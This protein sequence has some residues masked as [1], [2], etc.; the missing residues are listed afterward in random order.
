MFSRHV[1]GV[2][3]ASNE[4]LR[5]GEYI[6]LPS[7]SLFTEDHYFLEI[8]LI[9]W[10][11]LQTKGDRVILN[12]R[13]YTGCSLNDLLVSSGALYPTISGMLLYANDEKIGSLMTYRD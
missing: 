4:T 12:S 9:S 2:I 3:F 11:N 6:F 7:L 1:D 8:G 10:V 5:C 13:L